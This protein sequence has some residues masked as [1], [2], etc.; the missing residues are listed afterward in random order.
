MIRFRKKFFT[1]QKKDLKKIDPQGEFVSRLAIAF[2]IVILCFCTLAGRFYI[3]QVVR[4]DD[5]ITQSETNRISLIPTPPNR[6]TIVDI[7]GTVL[8]HNYYAYSLEVNLSETPY[9]IKTVESLK[10]YLTGGRTTKEVN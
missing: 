7:N 6:G 2:I 5:L 10:T 4:H 8:A 1:R 3:L 9:Q